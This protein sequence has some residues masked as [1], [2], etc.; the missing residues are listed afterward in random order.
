[1]D[2]NNLNDLM[3]SFQEK[4]KSVQEDGENK[5]FSARAGGGMVSVS[6][7]G[8]AEVVD[9]EIDDSLLEDKDALQILLIS[10]INDVV[11]MVED[12]KKQTAMNMLGGMNI[13]G[14]GK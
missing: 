7:N 14:G 4:A 6:M 13:F 5:V 9:L 2:L 11:K 10:S 3:S 8:N 12:Y 1:M